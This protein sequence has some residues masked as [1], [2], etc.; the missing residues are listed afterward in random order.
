MITIGAHPHV[1]PFTNGIQAKCQIT[2]RFFKKKKW[3]KKANSIILLFNAPFQILNEKVV[4]F[5]KNLIGYF[6]ILPKTWVCWM[7]HLH[8]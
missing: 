3:R 6:G 5:K 8:P 7:T 4:V 1:V 2:K